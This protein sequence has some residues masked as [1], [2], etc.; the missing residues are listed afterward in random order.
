MKTKIPYRELARR[1]RE[2]GQYVKAVVIP[3]LL[4]E[5]YLHLSYIKKTVINKVSRGE[6]KTLKDAEPLARHL[7]VTP[8]GETIVKLI[9]DYYQ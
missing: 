4:R 7:A 1:R 6:I 2:E 9:T 3:A 8:D 5:A